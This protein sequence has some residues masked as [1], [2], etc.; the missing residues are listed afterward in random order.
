MASE[1][2]SI[3]LVWA[4]ILAFPKLLAR[5]PNVPAIP[6]LDKR[7]PKCCGCGKLLLTVEIDV[8][9]LSA[10]PLMSNATRLSVSLWEIV[11]SSTA[12]MPPL[13]YRFD[14]FTHLV[15]CGLY[16]VSKMPTK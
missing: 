6:N 8:S 15:L 9:E 12:I 3:T 10:K 2:P 4:E 1:R 16:V 7:S 5:N 11:A 14:Y 13:L